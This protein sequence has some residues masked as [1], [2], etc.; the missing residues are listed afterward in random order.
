MNGSGELPLSSRITIQETEDGTVINIPSSGR[1][2]R[3]LTK[4]I[5]IYNIIVWA[6]LTFVTWDGWYVLIATLLSSPFWSFGLYGLL[7]YVNLRFQRI[8]ITITDGQLTIVRRR[9]FFLKSTQHFELDDVSHVR[10]Q[11]AYSTNSVDTMSVVLYTSSRRTNFATSQTLGEK[12]WLVTQI[13]EAIGVDPDGIDTSAVG[14]SLRPRI[15]V[16]AK[17][18]DELAEDSLI[19]VKRDTE[20]HMR[21]TLPGLPSEALLTLVGVFLLFLSLSWLA[22]I[23]W[24]IVRNNPYEMKIEDGWL[25]LQCAGHAI[26]AVAV[27]CFA[28]FIFMG[29]IRVDVTPTTLSRRYQIGPIGHSKSVPLNKIQNVALA[30]DMSRERTIDKRDITDV[31]QARVFTNLKETPQLFLTLFHDQYIAREVVALVN[32]QQQRM[33]S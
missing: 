20:Q 25:L 1:G 14:D 29:T 9:L 3:D 31:Q 5:F 18:P 30:F 8:R 23:S 10:L 19:R 21:F 33:K 15:E 27:L 7:S 12:N 13:N 28:L 17:A 4:T 26:V 22:A 11:S 6:I 24:W 2:I 32:Y 16:E